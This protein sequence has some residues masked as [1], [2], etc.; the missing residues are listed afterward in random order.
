MSLIGTNDSLFLLYS[1]I[2]RQIILAAEQ[3]VHPYFYLN[4]TFLVT[5][6]M[7]VKYIKNMYI[8]EFIIYFVVFLSSILSI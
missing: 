5:Y 1:L 6:K 2:F 4:Y 7:P 3:S 8:Y